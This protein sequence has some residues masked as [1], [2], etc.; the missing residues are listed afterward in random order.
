MMETESIQHI[1]TNHK[2]IIAILV[3]IITSS[4]SATNFFITSLLQDTDATSNTSL[5][6]QMIVIVNFLQA[7]SILKNLLLMVN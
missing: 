4:I 5:K 2:I 1:K 6:D 3:G 7:L